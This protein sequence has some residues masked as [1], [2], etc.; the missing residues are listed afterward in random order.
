[1][2]YGIGTDIV[3]IRR[4]EAALKRFGDRFAM[5]VLSPEEREPFLASEHPVRFLAK[6]FA[7]KEAFAKA[8][9]TGLRHPVTL[10]GIHVVHDVLGRPS[11]GFAPEL[12][13]A[14][15]ERG[16]RSHHLSISDEKEMAVAFV[17]L[18]Q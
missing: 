6:R 18:E 9:G 3:A 4:I 11:L 12:A 13:D 10:H 16:I 15:R 7:A 2:I 17:V 1:V 5:R 14:L 8:M